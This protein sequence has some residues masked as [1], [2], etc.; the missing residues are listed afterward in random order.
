VS[1]NGGSD[2]LTWLMEYLRSHRLPGPAGEP[3]QVDE[4]ARWRVEE[5]EDGR[6]GVL[7][8]GEPPGT[9]PDGIFDDRRVAY[10]MAAVFTAF[11]VSPEG[12]EDAAAQ[13]GELAAAEV[14]EPTAAGADPERR[15]R[16]IS[17]LFNGLMRNPAALELLLQAA[18]PEV[19]EQVQDI[20][21]Q[22]MMEEAGG[23]VH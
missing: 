6:F 8:E 17:R 23:K 11:G 14:R 1:G 20:L 2:P 5:V 21:V 9:A 15:G 13:A 7:R 19:L 22:R 18:E 16:A 3:I 4:G 10:L 12:G